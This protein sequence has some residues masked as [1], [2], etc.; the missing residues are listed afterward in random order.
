MPLGSKVAHHCIYHYLW[1]YFPAL[2]GTDLY[3]CWYLPVDSCFGIFIY[4]FITEFTYTYGGMLHVDSVVFHYT[5]SYI[6]DSSG[7]C[8]VRI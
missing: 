5:Y 6:H 2:G 7:I 3:P 4:T 1:R 8:L